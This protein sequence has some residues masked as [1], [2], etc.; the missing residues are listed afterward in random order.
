[1]LK[2]IKIGDD[3]NKAL[4]EEHWE[5]MSEYSPTDLASRLGLGFGG[6]KMNKLICKLGYQVNEDG[7]WVATDKAEGFCRQE[8]YSKDTLKKPYI[9]WYKSFYEQLKVDIDNILKK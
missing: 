2:T 5:N 4:A 9:R 8:Y 6:A 7:G 1:M 3:Y